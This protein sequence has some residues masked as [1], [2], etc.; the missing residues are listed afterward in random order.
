MEFS[1]CSPEAY[2]SSV[3]V[4][5]DKHGP[6][7]QREVEDFIKTRYA[8]WLKYAPRRKLRRSIRFLEKEGEIVRIIGG[9]PPHRILSRA[10]P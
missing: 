9:F 2:R 4:Y 10:K 5:L 6:S 8:R 1:K 3:S 7:K